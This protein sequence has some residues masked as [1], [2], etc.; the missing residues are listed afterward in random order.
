VSEGKIV[1]VVPSNGQ[2]N[3]D[4]QANT[5]GSVQVTPPFLVNVKTV[6]ASMSKKKKTIE[7]IVSEL[8]C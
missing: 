6:K 4:G 8:S 5:G 3:A 1:I 2:L 7:I